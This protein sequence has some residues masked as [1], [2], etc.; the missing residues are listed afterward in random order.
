MIVRRLVGSIF[1]L[2]L[3]AWVLLKLLPPAMPFLVALWVLSLFG[4]SVFA[5]RSL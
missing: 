1:L 2:M 3:V 5:R 4:A